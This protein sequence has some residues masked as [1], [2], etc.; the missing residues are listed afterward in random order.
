M[1]SEN[2]DAG[3]I[4]IWAQVGESLKKLDEKRIL[5]ITEMN[6]NY[7]LSVLSNDD[8]LLIIQRMKNGESFE[9]ILSSLND[10]NTKDNLFREIVR[11]LHHEPLDMLSVGSFVTGELESK[12]AFLDLSSGNRNKDKVNP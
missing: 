1:A 5:S 6:P 3:K 4:F 8:I 10:I 7:S 12:T 2:I 9:S 11:F